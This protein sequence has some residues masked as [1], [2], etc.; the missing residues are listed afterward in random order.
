MLNWF[1][2]KD[3]LIT[4]DM[5]MDYF[6]LQNCHAIIRAKNVSSAYAILSKRYYPGIVSIS[7]ISEV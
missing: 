7:E 4:F 5:V 6:S 2:K 3:Y 1:K